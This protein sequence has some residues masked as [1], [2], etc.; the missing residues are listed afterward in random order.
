MAQLWAE[1]TAARDSDSDVAG[2]E[3]SRPL[4]LEATSKPNAVS[5][6]ALE[7]DRVVAFALAHAEDAVPKVQFVA[8]A[9]D[10]WGR[11]HAGRVLDAM[12]EQLGGRGYASAR[13][14]VY[15]DNVQAMR[16]YERHGWVR[17]RGPAKPHSRTG[18]PEYTYTRQLGP[19]A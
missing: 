18:K 14:N 17:A 1:A 16:M 13:L 3:L 15:T 9:P 6:L 11:G 4:I 19:L 2:L 5:V 12:V 10:C 8:A 7:G